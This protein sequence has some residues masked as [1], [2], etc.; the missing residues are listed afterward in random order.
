MFVTLLL[1]L[2]LG[3]GDALLAGPGVACGKGC[4][5]AAVRPALLPQRATF[6]CAVSQPAPQPYSQAALDVMFPTRDEDKRPSRPTGTWWPV[7]WRFPSKK[8]VVLV[9]VVT[10]VLL[11]ALCLLAVAGSTAALSTVA[12][13]DRL[14]A[15][16][17]KTF[18]NSAGAGAGGAFLP[19]AAMTY[20]NNLKIDSFKTEL[21]SEVDS[22]VQRS[23]EE[24]GTI[25]QSLD[26]QLCLLDEV[27]VTLDVS[28]ELPFI[29]LD[30][31][32]RLLG[33]NAEGTFSLRPLK[34]ASKQ[35]ELAYVYK[36]A[37]KVWTIPSPAG[38]V[39]QRRINCRLTRQW[40][41]D[42]DVGDQQTIKLT[43]MRPLEDDP[44]SQ[45][46]AT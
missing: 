30:V 5:H 34:A 29:L 2:W 9:L 4:S 45:S 42:K 35:I 18:S 46:P 41:G 15:I 10:Y 1:S 25:Q 19:I 36:K 17:G 38:K 23:F 37:T 20:F 14:L 44:D 21:A 7:R 39:F 33:L 16:M 24:L 31:P 11:L 3:L 32:T 28:A 27:D 43:F 22:K 6:C 40:S 26:T 8:Q 12:S 13:E